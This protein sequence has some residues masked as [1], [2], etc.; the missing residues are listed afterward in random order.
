M[1]ERRDPASRPRIVWFDEIDSTNTEAQRRAAAGERGPLWIAAR[2]QTAGRG[3]SGRTWQSSGGNLAA[4][5]V[6]GLDV[7]PARLPELSFVS[8]L[9]AHDAITRSLGEVGSPDAVRLKWPNDV[10][11]DGEKVCGIL[12]ETA[13]YDRAPVMMFGIGINVESPPYV[14]GR[15]VTALRLHGA[16]AD[17]TRVLELLATAM[18]QWLSVWRS[19]G[20]FAEIREAWLA[21]SLPVGAPMSVDP[22]SGAILGTFA[23]LDNDGALLLAVDGGAER[24]FTYGDV[25]IV[26]TKA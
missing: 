3:R 20:G 16:T 6:L 2:W 4:T 24:R 7:A 19:P 10:L 23:G 26:S 21:R 18:E 1:P 25:T 13:H 9:A 11:I 12:L 22:G 5:L 8:G 17:A 15:T 14:P